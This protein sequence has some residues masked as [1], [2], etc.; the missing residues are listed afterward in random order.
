MQAKQS[1]PNPTID[2]RGQGLNSSV[3]KHEAVMIACT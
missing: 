1:K 3:P 2:A